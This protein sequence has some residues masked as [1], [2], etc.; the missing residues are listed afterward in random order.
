MQLNPL[1]YH[2]TGVLMMNNLKLAARIVR[3][4]MQYSGGL[5]CVRV[6]GCDF[7]AP[8][9]KTLIER[10]KNWLDFKTAQENKPD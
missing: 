5:F 2:L 8:D 1:P 10:V 6:Q 9:D 4:N 7:S 3:D